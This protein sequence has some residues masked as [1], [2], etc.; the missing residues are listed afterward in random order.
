ML[1][2]FTE[3]QPGLCLGRSHLAGHLSMVRTNCQLCA[4]SQLFMN[5]PEL[6]IWTTALDSDLLNIYRFLLLIRLEISLFSTEE[7]Q[8]IES[9][10]KKSELR[11]LPEICHQ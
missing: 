4:R 1:D 7:S 9:N 10:N 8:I 6:P 3:T 5:G 11:I 2:V